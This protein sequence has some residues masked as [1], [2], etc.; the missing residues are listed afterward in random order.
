M[1]SEAEG[2]SGEESN[3]GEWPWTVLLFS[4]EEYVGAGTLMDND[5]VVTTATKVEEDY[6][7]LDRL[8]R[9][10]KTILMNATQVLDYLE[11]PE[12][13]SV[14]MG[15]WDPKTPGPNSREDFPH[16]TLPAACI[17][18]HPKFD[19]RSLAYNVA[20][21]TLG[22]LREPRDIPRTPLEESVAS[23]VEIRSAP[24]RPADHPEGV[25]G[26]RRNPG[27]EE[28]VGL[29]QGG[30]RERLQKRKQL[31]AQLT[32]QVMKF[33]TIQISSARGRLTLK[34]QISL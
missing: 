29:R 18:L 14:K 2:G 34:M 9:N 7:V 31:L 5:V 21:I 4:G 13:L 22:G 20:V 3:P 11:R 8:F 1:K 24:R 23:V 17:R 27:R 19:R 33:D 6:N 28:G 25:E 26:S 32:Q 30:S 10:I 16:V 15:D 12:S